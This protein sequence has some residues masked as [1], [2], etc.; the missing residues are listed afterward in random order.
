M[1]LARKRFNRNEVLKY[2]EEAIGIILSVLI[3]SVLFAFLAGTAWSFLD[4][5]LF[6]ENNIQLASRTI[7]IDVLTLLAILEVL[8]TILIYFS[9][10]RVRVSYIVDTVLVVML[11]EVMIFW[12]K[13]VNY[14][15]IIAL[16]LVILCLTLV[17]LLAIKYSPAKEETK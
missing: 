15:R 7:I 17:R 13:D 3:I 16:V 8:K 12:F 11:T 14:E 5:K 6:F 2:F 10:G 1:E 4:L 9:E